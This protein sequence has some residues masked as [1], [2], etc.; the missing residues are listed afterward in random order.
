M[1][2]RTPGLQPR[3]AYHAYWGQY[4]YRDIDA[5]NSFAGRTADVGA[6]NLPNSTNNILNATEF[7]K[8]E[9]GDTAATVDASSPVT[10]TEFGLWTCIRPGT[11]GV[12]NAVWVRMD[13]GAGITTIRDAHR[14]VVGITGADAVDPA[15]NALLNLDPYIAGYSAD[16]IDVGDGAALALALA[17]A[18]AIS[19]Q[20]TSVDLR[21]VSGDIDFS[22]TG[23]AAL[24]LSIPQNCR[25]LGAGKNLTEITGLNATG[26]DQQIFVLEDNATLEGVTLISKIP[27]GPAAPS[28]GGIIRSNRDFSVRDVH[29]IVEDSANRSTRKGIEGSSFEVTAS[30]AYIERVSIQFD[31]A[32]VNSEG[33]SLQDYGYSTIR[34][35][36]CADMYQ[37]VHLISASVPNVGNRLSNIS[38]QGL[39]RSGIIV[40]SQNASITTQLTL[41]DSAFTF[42]PDATTLL[43]CVLE[44][45]SLNTSMIKQVNLSGVHAEWPSNNSTVPTRAFADLQAEDTS[46]MQGVSFLGCGIVSGSLLN[47]TEPTNGVIITN[48]SAVVDAI[49][50][51]D[52]LC[53]FA[54]S[55]PLAAAD[56]VLQTG[57]ALWEHAHPKGLA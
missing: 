23:V 31:G 2:A 39:H 25:V 44:A 9:A 38:G 28:S 13:Q 8:L 26:A 5:S 21:I 46:S 27:T 30:Q 56:I 1:A 54:G 3:S 19:G 37:A 16:F 12:G 11:F 22:L 35:V 32:L 41:S 48:A 34:D 18:T 52:L 20:G 29:I 6:D 53:D 42:K 47:F 33:V 36:D 10:G 4:Q 50:G 24:P 17:T 14:I 40:E 45:Q 55:A 49:R 43:Q 7:A 15:T 57:S 51:G